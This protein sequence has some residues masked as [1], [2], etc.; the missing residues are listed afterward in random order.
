[1]RIAYLHPGAFPRSTPTVSTP[2]GCATR[3]PRPDMRSRCTR[4]QART[5]STTRT[6]TTEYA[7]T[8]P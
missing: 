6:P 2:C 1:M 5:P 3:S 8:S 4:R 7:T